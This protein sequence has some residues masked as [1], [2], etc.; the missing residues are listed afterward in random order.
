MNNI[1]FS[2]SYFLDLLV[3]RTTQGLEISIY[4]KPVCTDTVIYFTS[5]NPIE[6]KRAALQFLLSRMHQLPLTP[7]NKEQE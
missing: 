2:E 3:H 7:K 1:A 5:R 4:R 6:H